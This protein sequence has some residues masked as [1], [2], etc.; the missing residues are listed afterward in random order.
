MENLNQG[1]K[2]EPE[3]KTFKKLLKKATNKYE[4]KLRKEEVKK[5]EKQN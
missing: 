5:L 4:D 1:L 2:L 3:N